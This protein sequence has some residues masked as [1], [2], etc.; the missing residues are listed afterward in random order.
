[1]T[2]EKIIMPSKEDVIRLLSFAAKDNIT[3]MTT[4]NELLGM[5]LVD[6]WL[7]KTEAEPEWGFEGLKQFFMEHKIEGTDTFEDALLKLK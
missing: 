6:S 2:A 4:V 5:K 3:H 7:P 1:M